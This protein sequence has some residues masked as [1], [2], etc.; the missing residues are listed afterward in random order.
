MKRAVSSVAWA[1]T[2]VDGR[3]SRFTDSEAEAQSWR[4]I[5]YDVKKFIC[6]VSDK[7]FQ[8][9]PKR[10]RTS[11]GFDKKA[12]IKEYMRKRRK[13]GSWGNAI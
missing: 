7:A 10:G 1:L 5:G 11:T 3:V 4:E 12:Y 2:G 8:E 9:I 6:D 13:R